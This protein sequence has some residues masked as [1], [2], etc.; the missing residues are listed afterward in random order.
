MRN[1][2]RAF[3]APALAVAAAA[4]LMA[5]AAPTASA[6]SSSRLVFQEEF[7]GGVGIGECQTVG[8]QLLEQGRF[9]RFVCTTYLNP[10]ASGFYI[11]V[12]D[13]YDDT[14]S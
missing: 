11:T 9:A 14:T 4:A 12:L 7:S 5:V 3:L 6:S 1:R 13:G 2:S 8:Q 10:I